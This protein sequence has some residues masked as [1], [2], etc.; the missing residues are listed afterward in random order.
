MLVGIFFQQAVN[1]KR[2][3]YNVLADLLRRHILFFHARLNAGNVRLRDI[4]RCI[5]FHK[6]AACRVR[7]GAVYSEQVNFSKSHMKRKL[8]RQR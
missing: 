7:I 8:S 2:P 4:P 1:D 6:M 3:V 5:V